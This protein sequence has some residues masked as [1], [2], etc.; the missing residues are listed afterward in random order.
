MYDGV[1]EKIKA[2]GGF[3]VYPI[4]IPE[5]VHSNDRLKHKGLS[6]KE[7]ACKLYTQRKSPII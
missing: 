3:V 1:A 5:A 2:N 4:D 7:V 6:Q